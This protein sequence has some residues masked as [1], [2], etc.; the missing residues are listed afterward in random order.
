MFQKGGQSLEKNSGTKKLKNR[1]I[2]FIQ[3]AIQFI[4]K[5][6][7][8]SLFLKDLH[9]YYD[10]ASD[11]LNLIEFSINFICK[12]LRKTETELKNL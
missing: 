12:W 9:F 4:I 1:Q 3:F 5:T 7:M 11:L 10:T 8:K 2:R 6:I